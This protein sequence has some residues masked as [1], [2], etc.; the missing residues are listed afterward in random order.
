MLGQ[1]QG[2]R[3]TPCHLKVGNPPIAGSTSLNPMPA[4]VASNDPHL[5]QANAFA[6]LRLAMSDTDPLCVLVTRPAK[7]G[8]VSRLKACGAVSNAGSVS[9]VWWYVFDC[10][11]RV[12]RHERGSSLAGQLTR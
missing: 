7:L 3:L 8:F 9:R 4:N 6:T 2:G 10:A 1:L 11:D 5:M 12:G